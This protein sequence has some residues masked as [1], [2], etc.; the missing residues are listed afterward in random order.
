MRPTDREPTT[1]R[2]SQGVLTQTRDVQLAEVMATVVGVFAGLGVASGLCN[3]FGWDDSAV[4]A[5]HRT[6]SITT[7]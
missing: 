2:V 3:L 7:G 6:L 1:E 4:G 5:D